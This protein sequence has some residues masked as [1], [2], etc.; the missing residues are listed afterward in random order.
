MLRNLKRFRRRGPPPEV[1]DTVY[2][3]LVAVGWVALALLLLST[4]NTRIVGG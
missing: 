2:A 1:V 4:L 3:V